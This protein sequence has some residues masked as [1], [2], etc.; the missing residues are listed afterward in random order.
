[1]GLLVGI[2]NVAFIIT[3]LVKIIINHP[4]IHSIIPTLKNIM[5]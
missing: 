3:V 5:P 2:V 4:D 1:M